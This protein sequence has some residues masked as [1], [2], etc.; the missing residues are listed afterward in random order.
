MQS[1]LW[2]TLAL[3][4]STLYSDTAHSQLL[5]TEPRIKL[6]FTPA[7]A[8][9][10]DPRI[11]VHY[12]FADRDEIMFSRQGSSAWVRQQTWTNLTTDCAK[13]SD[14]GITRLSKACA[15]AKFQISPKTIRRD[16]VYPG[17]LNLG[18]NGV[19]VYA[20]YLLTEATSGINVVAPSEYKA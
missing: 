8:S 3:L 9:G 4:C 17:V 7:H 15:E 18:R 10:I 16:R 19:L 12:L 5:P 1:T 11:E 14:R 2:F 20:P 13:L 6:V